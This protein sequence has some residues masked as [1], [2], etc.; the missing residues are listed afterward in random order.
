MSPF[1][2]LVYQHPDRF[3]RRD[4][5]ESFAQLRNIPKRGVQVGAAREATLR[6]GARDPSRGRGTCR[7][8]RGAGIWREIPAERGSCP[9]LP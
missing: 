8:R 5:D 9:E 1:D 3:S 4:G 7:L 6:A 2:V